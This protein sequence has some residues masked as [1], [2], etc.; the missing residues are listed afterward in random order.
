MQTVICA[1]LQTV[2]SFYFVFFSVLDDDD[3][4]VSFESVA[5]KL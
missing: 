5:S 4:E 2:I 3:E 1:T